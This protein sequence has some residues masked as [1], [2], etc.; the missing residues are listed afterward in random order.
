M[1]TAPQLLEAETDCPAVGS[2]VDR[3]VMRP[4]ESRTVAALYVEPKGCY[5]GVPGVLES[6][7]A[8]QDTRSQKGVPSR[9]SSR[10]ARKGKAD[11]RSMEGRKP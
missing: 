4:V 5:V 7:H 10:K 11:D 3:R 1:T 9:V 2:P 6:R 8:T